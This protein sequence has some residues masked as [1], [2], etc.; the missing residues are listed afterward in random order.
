ME[1]Y[2]HTHIHLHGMYRKSL[3]Y[4]Y[5]F[6]MIL[7]SDILNKTL[8]SQPQTMFH[9]TTGFSIVLGILPLYR[10]IEK[11]GRDFKP[12]YLKKYWTDLHVWRLEMLR[13][14]LSFRLT[15]VHF[16]MCTV[17]SSGDVSCHVI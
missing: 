4:I 11:D 2:L 6:L 12:L 5:T 10:V 8:T 15:L 3:L 7:I 16:N 14:L 1:L 13:K 17:C 9:I